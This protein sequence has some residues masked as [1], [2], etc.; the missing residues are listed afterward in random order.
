MD[1]IKSNIKD[2]EYDDKKFELMFD[3]SLLQDI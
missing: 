3:F 2:K 1:Y